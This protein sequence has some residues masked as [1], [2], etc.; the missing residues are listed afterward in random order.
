MRKCCTG[1]ICGPQTRTQGQALI[2]ARLLW[3]H[4]ERRLAMVNQRSGRL[5]ASWLAERSLRHAP[6]FFRPHTTEAP[7]TE[8]VPCS[9]DCQARPVH[10]DAG[11]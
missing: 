6:Q 4:R 9:A 11:A 3:A 5:P 2:G 7:E 8:I 1:C 10:W